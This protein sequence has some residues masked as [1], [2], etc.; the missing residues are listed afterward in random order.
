MR[1]GTIRDLMAMENVSMSLY[2]YHQP[3]IYAYIC[4]PLPYIYI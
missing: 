3:G 4:V 1:G 2:M